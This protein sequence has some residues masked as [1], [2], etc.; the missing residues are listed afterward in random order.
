M[1]EPL[2][3]E[4]D[5]WVVLQMRNPKFARAYYK[6]VYSEPLPLRAD[7]REYRRR[8]KRRNRR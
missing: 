8:Q 6:F 3:D 5:P 7:G 4:L 1:S 2:A